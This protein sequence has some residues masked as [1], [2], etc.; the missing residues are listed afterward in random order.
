M[1]SQQDSKCRNCHSLHLQQSAEDVVTAICTSVPFGRYCTMRSFRSA[2][3]PAPHDTHAA[4][5]L[6]GNHPS[7]KCPW[8][9]MLVAP[10]AVK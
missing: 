9:Q 2:L 6:G 5:S 4:A 8:G 10:L 7:L 1:L 3:T